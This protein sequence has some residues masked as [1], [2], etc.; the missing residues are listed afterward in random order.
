MTPLQ[1]L[2]KYGHWDMRMGFFP[3]C[4]RFQKNNVFHFY[5]VIAAKKILRKKAVLYIGVAQKEY[6][7]IHIEKWVGKARAVAIKGY[8][9]GT[10]DSI[11]CEW[12]TL[13]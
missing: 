13:V 7:T 3:G 1:Q 11:Q 10:L 4:Y 6:V 2:R 5:G 8:G 12:Y 9:T